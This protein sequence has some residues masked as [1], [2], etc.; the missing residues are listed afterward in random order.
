MQR[1]LLKKYFK[2]NLKHLILILEKSCVKSM[3][4]VYKV[5]ILN[6]KNYQTRNQ[7]SVNQEKWN[8]LIKL[9]TDSL[10]I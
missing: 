4:L 2:D 8:E 5:I 9:K 6:G 1:M 3:T 7:S 10:R